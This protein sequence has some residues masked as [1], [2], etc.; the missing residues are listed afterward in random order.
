M[1]YTI[2]TERLILRPFEI[3]DA[4]EMFANWAN[5]ERV[6]RYLSW[7]THGDVALTRCLM[8][9]WVKEYER[10]DVYRFGITLKETG[11]LFGSIDIVRYI[12]GQPEI[13][14][15]S[16]YRFWGHGYMT[17]AA[18]AVIAFLKD[19]GFK[20]VYIRA[21]ER[22]VGSNRVIQKCGLTFVKQITVPLKK[23]NTTCVTNCYEK[24]L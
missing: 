21:D 4:E 22:N 17:E 1:R 8:E 20:K 5:D 7:N 12:D 19:Q 2:E 16:A 23:N 9:Q 18:K 13:G 6:C 24:A 11:E 3:G 14:Y 15:C 10:P